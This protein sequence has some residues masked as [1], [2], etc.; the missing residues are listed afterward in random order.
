MSISLNDLANRL[1]NVENIKSSWT[2]GNTSNGDWCKESSTGLLIQWGTV[3]VSHS[4]PHYRTITL[5]KPF[6]N[7]NYSV[8]NQAFYNR[9]PDIDDGAPT[10]RSKYTDKF[11]FTSGSREFNGKPTIY[12]AIGY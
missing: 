5:P 4:D 9:Q 7:T 11:I 1:K 6:T 10:I 12:I 2:K 8:I 3:T